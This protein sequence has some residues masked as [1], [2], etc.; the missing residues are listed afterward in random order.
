M[1]SKYAT[2][3]HQKYFYHCNADTKLPLEALPVVRHKDE[4]VVNK[5]ELYSINSIDNGVILEARRVAQ[6]REGHLDITGH[7]SLQKSFYISLNCLPQIANEAEYYST[8]LNNTF[9]A[10]GRSMQ[11]LY[12]G[13]SCLAVMTVNNKIITVNTGASVAYHLKRDPKSGKVMLRRLNQQHSFNN[14]EEVA[15]INQKHPTHFHTKQKLGRLT[16]FLPVTRAFGATR[17]TE[18]DIIYEPTIESIDANAKDS[19][20]LILS[21]N[22]SDQISDQALVEIINNN[23]DYSL[24]QIA[25]QIRIQIHMRNNINAKYTT[26]MLAP[27]SKFKSEA[28]IAVLAEGFFLAGVSTRIRDDFTRILKQFLPGH[29]NIERITQPLQRSRKQALAL[30][31]VD[32]YIHKTLLP[33]NK[34]ISRLNSKFELR[35]SLINLRDQLLTDIDTELQAIDNRT[36]QDKINYLK[37]S[38]AMQLIKSTEQMINVVFNRKMS[39][40]RK[41]HRIHNYEQNAKR[42]KLW[43]TVAKSVA[44]VIIAATSAVVYGT[45]FA[46]VGIAVGAWSGPGAAASGIAGL[47]YGTVTGWAAGVAATAA[48]ASCITTGVSSY[49]LFKKPR[50]EK[51]FDE[52]KLRSKESVGKV[53]QVFSRKSVSL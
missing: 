21:H 52:V 7:S 30:T 47:I 35:L 24:D 20:F 49:W 33:L 48:I 27:V 40:E 42:N 23:K 14:A 34:H 28:A 6:S 36:D 26:I 2:V 12:Q 29:V 19:Y 13:S 37:Q 9:M 38:P 45:I 3:I 10:L 22:I 41:L 39:A 53:T 25:E 32:E 11:Q 5:L 44:T 1:Q 46:G 17:Y 43:K 15:R 8:A 31:P 51:L 4:Q 16:K 18:D 50:E